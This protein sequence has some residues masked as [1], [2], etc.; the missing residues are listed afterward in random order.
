MNN[1]DVIL[2]FLKNTSNGTISNNVLSGIITFLNTNEAFEVLEILKDEINNELDYHYFFESLENIDKL[3]KLK[4]TDIE[5][6]Y[7]VIHYE[8]ILI[9]SICN[10]FELPYIVVL[11]PD[12]LEKSTILTLKFKN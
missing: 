9:N 10:V 5:V 3:N 2:N 8:T 11:T 1:V 6:Y 12:D 4:E 7:N